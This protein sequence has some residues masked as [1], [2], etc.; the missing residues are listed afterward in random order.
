V[1]EAVELS[2]GAAHAVDQAV[3]L[4]L[5]GHVAGQD[6]LDAELRRQL[7]HVALQALVGVGQRELHALALERPGAGPGHRAL[8]RHAEDQARLSVEESHAVVSCRFRG[9][10]ARPRAGRMHAARAGS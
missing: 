8:V 10:V 9:V 7:A 6:G 4:A 1:H 5:L 2:E 3:D